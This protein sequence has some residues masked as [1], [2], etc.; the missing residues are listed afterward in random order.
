MTIAQIIVLLGA[1]G[2]SILV[3][4]YF[5]FRGMW[6]V[7]TLIYT[8]HTGRLGEFWG[9]GIGLRAF[10]PSF[11]LTMPLAF[12]AIPLSMLVVNSGAWCIVP[13]RRHFEGRSK[14]YGEPTF[15]QTMRCLLHFAKFM[16]P[17]SLLLSLIGVMTL[18]GLR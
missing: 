10:V 11:L 12:A 1:V 18:S 17:V 4:W 9:E 8:E 5:L 16:I 6:W 3:I 13:L 15:R 7:H 2:L 14:A